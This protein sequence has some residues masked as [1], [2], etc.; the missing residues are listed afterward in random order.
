MN[1]A[2]IKNTAIFVTVLSVYLGLALIGAPPHVLAQAVNQ[3][4][5]NSANEIQEFNRKPLEDFRQRYIELYRQGKI[6]LDQEFSI[7]INIFAEAD[8]KVSKTK[9][10]GKSGDVPLIDIATDLL[11]ASFETGFFDSL[12]YTFSKNKRPVDFNL[13][14]NQDKESLTILLTAKS[15]EANKVASSFNILASLAKVSRTTKEIKI[16]E[17]LLNYFQANAEGNNVSLRWSAPKQSVKQIIEHFT[18][19]KEK[20]EKSSE[21]SFYFRSNQTSYPVILPRGSLEKFFQAE[22]DVKK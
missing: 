18:V 13:T 10:T 8:G 11:A 2:N 1:Q 5:S 16:E 21:S 4:R 3:T 9:I 19:E 17:K 20:A 14:I 6:D 15:E 12:V 7:A 22:A